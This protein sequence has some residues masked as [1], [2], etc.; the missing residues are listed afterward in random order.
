MPRQ[1]F[2]ELLTSL[3]DGFVDHCHRD[4]DAEKLVEAMF[5]KVE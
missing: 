4:V 2:E 5:G 3:P 1:K